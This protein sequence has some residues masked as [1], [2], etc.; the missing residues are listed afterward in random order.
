M[1]GKRDAWGMMFT[2]KVVCYGLL[3]VDG[4]MRPTSCISNMDLLSY[5][6]YDESYVVLNNIDFV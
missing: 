5:H 1:I 2:K 3:V 4:M 6:N